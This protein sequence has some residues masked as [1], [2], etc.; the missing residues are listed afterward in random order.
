MPIKAFISYSHSDRVLAK[1]IKDEL[2]KYGVSA[3]LAHN[4]I[5][6]SEEWIKEILTA[7]NSCDIFLP[8]LTKSFS[9]SSWTDQEAGI[10]FQGEKLI[11]PLKVE[12]DPY[13]FIGRFQ[14]LKVNP[15][16]L[17]F[18]CKKIA[19]I[20][21]RHPEHG[22][23]FRDELIAIFGKSDSYAES[24]HNAKLLVFFEGYTRRQVRQIVRH[25][26]ENRQIHDSY[27]AKDA[28]RP[29]IR[30]FRDILSQ[31]VIDDFDNVMRRR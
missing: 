26:I 13:G 3:F 27:D 6:P 28:L 14:A 5:E 16:R 29:F 25:I 31:Q 4:D 10:A 19:L 15:D 9:K 23:A 21:S 12:I 11:I 7:L 8:I 30:G 1:N 22:D 2:Q 20:V 17:S 18:V 24:A